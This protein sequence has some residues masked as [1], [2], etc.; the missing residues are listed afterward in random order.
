MERVSDTVITFELEFNG[1]LDT[2]ATL[3][4]TVGADAIVEYDGPAR[5]A[6]I[7]VNGGQESVIASTETPVDRNYAERKCRYTD[8]Q[9]GN[10]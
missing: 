1:N 2:N 10:L 8:T 5:I 7:I 4:F 3:I 6:Q 9:R